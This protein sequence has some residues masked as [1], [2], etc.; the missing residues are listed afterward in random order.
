VLVVKIRKPARRV[1]VFDLETLAAGYAD[2]SWVPDKITVA[3]WSWL[4][5]NGVESLTTGKD[6][7]FSA[8]L[9]GERLGPLLDAIREA[10]MLVGHNILRFDL[11]VL[12]AESIRCDLPPLGPVLTHDTI[13]LLR[14]KGLKKGQDDLSV[15]VG[16]PLKKKTLNWSEWDRAYEE[17]GWP[18]PVERCVSDVR[19][20]KTLYRRLLERGVL[21][22]ERMWRP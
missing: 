6:G 8:R 13:R 14:T 10:D 1:L 5:E 17:D 15:M 18:V 20:N 2:P 7:F 12:Q 3:A 22:P 9:R 16:S 11:P 4:D 21:R 19:Q